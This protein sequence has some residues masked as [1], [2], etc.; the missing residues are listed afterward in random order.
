MKETV[1]ISNLTITAKW[2]KGD[3]NID[4]LGITSLCEVIDMCVK[5]SGIHVGIV[6]KNRWSVI[7]F[8]ETFRSEIKHGRLEH[9][10]LISGANRDYGT[11]RSPNDSFIYLINSQNQELLKGITFQKVLYESGISDEILNQLHRCER[12]VSTCDDKYNTE[13]LDAFLRSFKIV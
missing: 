13:E 2:Y 3:D 5:Q 1:N 11:I 9:W 6:F 4:V 12:G 10:S 7:D 8:K